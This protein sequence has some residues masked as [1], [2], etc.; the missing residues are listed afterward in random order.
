MI[1]SSPHRMFLFVCACALIWLYFH[2][3]IYTWTGIERAYIFRFALF[4]FA[5]CSALLRSA[6]P[7]VHCILYIMHSLHSIVLY[8]LG[9]SESSCTRA[10]TEL[11]SHSLLFFFSS[12]TFSPYVCMCLCVLSWAVFLIFILVFL[13]F[14][15]SI[16]YSLVCAFFIYIQNN[17][18]YPVSSTFRK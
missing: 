4:C 17:I 15:Y 2:V 9:T 1:F 11:V 14:Y 16:L 3:Y 13:P 5:V 7:C 18:I 8:F 12:R 10:H 6:A